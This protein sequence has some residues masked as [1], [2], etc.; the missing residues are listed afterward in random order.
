MIDFAN[1]KLLIFDS[2]RNLQDVDTCCER[3]VNGEGGI[4]NPSLC[5]ISGQY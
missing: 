1:S 3:I 2:R 4:S 5:N